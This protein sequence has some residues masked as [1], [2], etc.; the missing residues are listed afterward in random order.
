MGF[1]QVDE[2]VIG[3]LP[4]ERE[5]IVMAMTLEDSLKS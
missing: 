3:P 2:S 4:Y 1:N 5:T